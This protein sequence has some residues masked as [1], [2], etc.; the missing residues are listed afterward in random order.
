MRVTSR[1]N[2]FAI[3]YLD[4]RLVK[5]WITADSELGEVTCYRT[6]D[7]FKKGESSF[8]EVKLQGKVVILNGNYN[9]KR[10]T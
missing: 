10:Q 3:V 6:V 1:E 8:E 7:R 9:T 5:D 2:V 4:D